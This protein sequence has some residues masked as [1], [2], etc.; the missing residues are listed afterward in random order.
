MRYKKMTGKKGKPKTK[1]GER[2]NI[3]FTIAKEIKE[4]L[5]S[6]AEKNGVT[7]SA[8]VTMLIQQSRRENAALNT[9]AGVITVWP[10]QVLGVTCRGP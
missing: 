3:N 6:E 4:F 8:F 7:M 10:V 2:V 9:L 5:R 1:L